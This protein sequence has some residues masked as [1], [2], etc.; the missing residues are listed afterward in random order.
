MYLLSVFFKALGQ[1]LIGKTLH[2][3]AVFSVFKN[4]KKLQKERKQRRQKVK[5]KPMLSIFQVKQVIVNM[6]QIKS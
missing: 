6:T 4:L 3:T 1:L 5:G 2:I